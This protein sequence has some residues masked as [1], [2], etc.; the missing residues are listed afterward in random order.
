MTTTTLSQAG[1][2]QA[3]PKRWL[4]LGILLSGIFLA[5]L[6]FFI[7][8]VALPPI[9]HGLQASPGQLQLTIA[10]F[11]ISYAV[12]LITGGRL[13]DFYGRRRL[14]LAGLLVFI[15]SS[16]FCGFSTSPEML[17]VGRALQGLSAAAM[18]PQGI[19]TIHVIF[20]D[21]EKLKALGF[22]GATYGLASA[23][24]QVVGGILISANIMGLGW[25]LIFL[26]NIPVGIVVFV[27]GLFLLKDSRDTKP[28]QFDWIGVFMLAVALLSLTVP[29]SIGPG[30][31]WPAWTI[32]LMLLFPVI[33]IVFLWYENRLSRYGNPI[34]NPAAFQ[35]PTARLGLTIA[36]L[37]YAIAAFFLIY[38][39]YLQSALHKSALEAGLLFSPFGLGFLVATLMPASLKERVKVN[40][41][42]LGLL[43]EVIGLLWLSGAITRLSAEASLFNGLYVMPPIFVM[44]IGLGFALPSL[45]KEIIVKT[46]P[47]YAGLVSGVINSSL[48][49]SAALGVAGIGSVFY[50]FSGDNTNYTMIATSFSISLML[51]AL[52]LTVASFLVALMKK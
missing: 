30:V 38:S 32:A 28:I 10:A 16:A 44:G 31:G 40:M 37:F 9:G 35:S 42:S 48:Q 21:G 52:C 27:A 13:G 1:I 11:S 5:P 36:L 39:V 50:V 41:L 46:D 33:A 12:F 51:I 14:F 23:I 26:I 18:V 34:L 15:A 22:Y 19:A 6:D 7:I 20:P 3:E 49:I 2:E 25:R 17:I 8:N 4:M 45:L 29:L 24:G 43:L 47:Q